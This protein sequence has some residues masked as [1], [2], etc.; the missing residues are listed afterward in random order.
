MKQNKKFTIGDYLLTR[1]FQM[2]ITDLFGVP[3]DY[4]LAFLDHVTDFKG[5]QWRGNTNELNAAYATDGYARV[6]G[7]GAFLTTFGVGELSSIN[8]VAGSFAE[9]V[10]VIQIVG[11]PNTKAA[12]KGECKHHTL[13]DGDYA[14]FHRIYKE[15]TIASTYLSAN[16]TKNEIDR[17]LVASFINKK[18]GYIVLPTDIAAM[19][20]EAP[21]D[22]IKDQIVVNSEINSLKEFKQ[23]AKKLIQNNSQNISILSDYITERFGCISLVKSLL[24]KYN[25]PY[26]TMTAG[27]GSL[28][29]KNKNYLGIY[30]GSESSEQVLNYLENNQLLISIGCQFSDSLTNNF[31]NNIDAKLHIDIQGLQSI[32]AGKKFTQIHMKD[33]L[34]ILS[35]I[36]AELHIEKYTFSLKN[37]FGNN[38][39]KVESSDLLTQKA[40]WSNAKNIVNEGDIVIC[41]QGTSYFGITDY[42]LPENIQFI[43]QPV[44]GS[45]G[46]T[47]PATLGAQ[48]AA[49][50]KKVVLF[51][52]DGSALMTLQSLSEFIY[53]NIHPTIFV[54]NNDG[55]SV[56]RAINGPEEKYNDIP[57]LNWGKLMEAFANNNQEKLYVNEVKKIL[58]LKSVIYDLAEVNTLAFIELHLD[59][60]DY[61]QGI[62]NISRSI[63]A[64]NNAPV[65]H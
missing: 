51:I 38:P 36:F 63:N 29:E 47:L 52:G 13:G 10:P 46:Y 30:A 37:P 7:F 4:N 39:I 58:D 5:I 62:I 14:H 48:I 24:E 56:E 21:M 31:S 8:G 34:S 23:A 40:L 20:C 6:K 61:P 2:G 44:W 45:I 12:S 55:Y 53:H 41:E 18:P 17:V 33:A 64:S 59:K 3:G 9:N 50:N 22:N 35:E 32:V 19:P 42:S 26:A 60:I 57:S 54:L 1:L 16:N 27:K 11:A 28:G 49:P 65:K 25:F 43:G 15:V